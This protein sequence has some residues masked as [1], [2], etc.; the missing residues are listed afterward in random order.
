MRT[1]NHY[2]F[3]SDI[4]PI[5]AAEIPLCMTILESEAEVHNVIEDLWPERMSSVTVEFPAFGNGLGDCARRELM[6]ALTEDYRLRFYGEVFLTTVLHELAHATEGCM[7]GHNEEFMRHFR[8][9]IRRAKK[10]YNLKR[11]VGPKDFCRNVVRCP[12]CTS[13]Y[14]SALNCPL[15]DPNHPHNMQ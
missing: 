11:P 1:V 7:N 13:Q 4:D 10:R 14:C 9:L 5:E 15:F 8:A 3:N 2:H 12:C 6:G